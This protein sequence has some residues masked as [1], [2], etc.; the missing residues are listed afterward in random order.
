MSNRS[1]PSLRTSLRLA[2][3]LGCTVEPV[4]G[5]GEV[6]VQNAHGDRAR[7]NRRRKDASRRLLL[8]IRRAQ[9]GRSDD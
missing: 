2:A 7:V 6:V 1:T 4:R 3:A 8:V 9:G 5:T